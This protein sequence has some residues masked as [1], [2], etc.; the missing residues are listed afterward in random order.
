MRACGDVVHALPERGVLLSC[1]CAYIIELLLQL[2]YIWS[3]LINQ[4]AQ[5]MQCETADQLLLT[6]AR[7]SETVACMN[8]VTVSTYRFKCL[9]RV[10][11]H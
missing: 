10:Y 8:G 9:G 3:L 7:V 5:L 2:K 4:L 1:T 11:L 6:R